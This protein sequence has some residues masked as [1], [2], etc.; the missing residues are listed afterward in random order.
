MSISHGTLRPEDLIPAFLEAVPMRLAVMNGEQM[1]SAEQKYEALV[2]EY[3]EHSSQ[4]DWFTSEECSHFLN[5]DLFDL[6]NDIAPD[7]H[8]FSAHPGDGRDFGFWPSYMFCGSCETKKEGGYHCIF[9]GW[10]PAQIQ[11][12]QD[13]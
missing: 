4:P 13:G 1:Y 9:C 2:E 11:T 3:K 7:K 12:Y 8:V 5:E 10:S 6:M